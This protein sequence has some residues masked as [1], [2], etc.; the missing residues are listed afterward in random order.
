MRGMADDHALVARV[1]GGL[2]LL[3]IR[4]ARRGSLGELDQFDVVPS[5]ISFSCIQ[6]RPRG[7]LLRRS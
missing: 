7:V 3:P 2:G 6:D 4:V 5:L 1:A